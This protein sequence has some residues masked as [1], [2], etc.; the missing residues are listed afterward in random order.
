MYNSH[1][2][3]I[4]DWC[5]NPCRLSTE[6][7]GARFMRIRP[8]SERNYSVKENRLGKRPVKRIIHRLQWSVMGTTL[9]GSLNALRSDGV[10]IKSLSQP[11]C[12]FC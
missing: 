10:R 2:T 5:I 11:G 4:F 3:H 7:S 1:N 6:A 8:I 12:L 9:N